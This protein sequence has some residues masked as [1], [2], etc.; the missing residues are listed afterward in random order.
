MSCQIVAGTSLLLREKFIDKY[1][2]N[3]S[4]EELYARLI[5]HTKDLGMSAKFQGEGFL[6]INE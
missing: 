1:G 4:E 2:R 5:K 3:P 6:Y